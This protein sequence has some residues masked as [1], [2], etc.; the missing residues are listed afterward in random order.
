[1][2]SFAL[3]NINYYSCYLFYILLVMTTLLKENLQKAVSVV[4]RF[5]SLRP[6]LPV[7]GNIYIKGVKGKLILRVTNLETS[8]EISTPSKT[9]EEWEITVPGKLLLEFLNTVRGKEATIELEKESFVI[10]TEE[11]KG[12]LATI[13]ATE[14]PKPPFSEHP[15]ET[16]KFKAKDIY[17][18]ATKVAFA[19]SQDEGKPIL[20]SM[21]LTK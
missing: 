5:I 16:V 17:Q 2:I 14:F 18:I 8:I 4:N 1:M 20:N 6:T 21:Y 12:T 13:S 15:K 19:A 10:S 7:L 9:E 11:T 3:I